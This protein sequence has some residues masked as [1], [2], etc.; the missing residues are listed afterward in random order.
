M[1]VEDKTSIQTKLINEDVDS[2]GSKTEEIKRVSN[3]TEASDGSPVSAS[4]I[5]KEPG[6]IEST[7]GN[8]RQ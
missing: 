3:S 8:T 6:V 1:T 5:K 2:E 7:S 4:S